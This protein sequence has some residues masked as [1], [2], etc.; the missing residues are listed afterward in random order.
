MMH[1]TIWSVM[2]KQISCNTCKYKSCSQCSN[3]N[4][5]C[6]RNGFDNLGADVIFWSKILPKKAP[7]YAYA[8]WEPVWTTTYLP[9][10]LFEI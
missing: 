5:D 10:D 9:D 4:G 6:L 3:K 8:H 2:K 7:Q 1:K